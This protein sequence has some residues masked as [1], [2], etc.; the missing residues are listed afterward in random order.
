MSHSSETYNP[1]NVK[2]MVLVVDDEMINRE[3]L[4][5]ILKDDYDV[6]TAVDGVKALAA[7]RD[8]RSELA[9][10]MLDLL[11]PGMSGLELLKLIKNTKEFNQVPV[12]VLTSDRESEVACLRMGASDFISK[13]YPNPEVILA[14]VKRTIELYED[15]KLI[16]STEKDALTGLYS[17]EYFFSYAEE[18]DRHHRKTP[19]DAI[20]VNINHFH[21]IN[22]R[23]GKEY[24]NM[25]LRRVADNIRVMLRKTGGIACRLE[26][27]TFLIYCRHSQYYTELMDRASEDLKKDVNASG[28]RLRLR[29]G[30]YSEVDKDL[31][32]ERRFDRA[33]MAADLGRNTYEQT[34]SFY[35]S[36][37]HESH[38]YSEHL[39]ED[40]Q[41]AL[42]QHQFL[43]YYQPKFDIRAD[44][45]VLASAEALIR[46][47][48][49]RLG[50]ISPGVFIPLLENNGLIQQLDHYVWREAAAQVRRWKDKFGVTVPVSVNVSRIDMY[51]PDLIS[52]FRNIIEENRLST[53]EYH[54]EITESAYTDDSMHII[55]TVKQ[56]RRLGFRIE[57]D[58]FGSGYSSLNMLSTLPIDAL[59]LDM[60]FIRTAFTG[61][62]DTRMIELIIDIAEYLKV[63][64]IA[65]GVET[66]EQMSTLK[67]LGCDYVQG[68]YFSRP[69][70]PEEFEPFITSSPGTVAVNAA[71]AA[72]EAEEAKAEPAV[73]EEAAPEEDPEA[74]KLA[75]LYGIA[76]A[77]SSDFE[78]VYYVDLETEDY[79]EF[80][81]HGSKAFRIKLNGVNF[82][83]ECQRNLRMVA[84]PED[85]EK[86]LN[87]MCKEEISAAMKL[88]PVLTADY[89]QLVDGRPEYYRLKIVRADRADE[90][91]VVIGVS[92]IN[93]QKAYQR[94]QQQ[95]FEKAHLDSVTYGRIAQALA[96]DFYTIYYVNLDTN[97]F[98]EFSSSD[99]YRELQIETN[100]I[101][102]FETCLHAVPIT[103]HEEDV[104]KVLYVLNKENMLRELEKN[105]SI[106]TS[107]RLILSGEAVYVNLKIIRM[108]ETQDGQHYV[109]AAISN[110]NAQMKRDQEFAEAQITA[111]KDL[112]TGVKNRRA[113][114][115][116]EK[117][118]NEAIADGSS[119]DFGIVVCNVM[120][121]NEMIAAGSAK[122][123]DRMVSEACELVCDMFRH[124]PVYRLSG[125]QFT[126]ILRD[127][128][129]KNEELIMKLFY[130]AL[131][132]S[133]KKGGA[134]LAT[135]VSHFD[136]SIDRDLQ[137][138]FERANIAMY[139]NKMELKKKE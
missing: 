83:G 115:K 114:I 127:R 137:S 19:M 82:F 131:D 7:I 17:R 102:F 4:C 54:L 46:W 134:A 44:V 21:I 20:L 71:K 77:L 113:F 37:L 43:V 32:I 72:A 39:L 104:D 42:G 123:A 56:L 92:N 14:R 99:K 108:D 122:K 64:V 86:L 79:T 98:M 74:K 2:R 111:M 60:K 15:R 76:Q 50:M 90:R 23:Y 119:G 97:E 18:L 120:G 8:H 136:P 35:D 109:I 85:K 96:K 16:R 36:K 25:V 22:E 26:A 29:M 100:G 125:D 73:R 139:E 126:V 130:T 59:K 63:P 116:E 41:T 118:I 5:Q 70:P 106:S 75:E 93:G 105:D 62:K 51:D 24:G 27:D 129:L 103:V 55:D 40:F 45:P 110:I 28:N 49:P 133:R 3:I 135:G 31:D 48:H 124:S 78:S 87:L 117:E 9:L 6:I 95:K 38:L 11:M 91:H 69:V 47:K 65:E 68:Y 61:R 52:I 94:A 112:L 53:T 138:V 67:N 10:I 58:D 34:I 66:E 84:F 57:M 132:K 1:V 89:R 80:N 88:I 12:I 81:A 13:P 121:V 101:D 30:V 128:D 33:K 107:Y